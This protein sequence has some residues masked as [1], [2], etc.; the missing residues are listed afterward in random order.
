[1]RSLQSAKSLSGKLWPTGEFS[2]GTVKHRPD[3]RL[4]HRP[5]TVSLPGDRG[6]DAAAWRP[7]SEGGHGPI[8]LSNV[9][10]SQK[11]AS[12]PETYG[13]KGMTGYGKKMVKSLGA[14]IDRD[15]PNHRVTFATVTMPS[16]PQSE[17]RQMAE[18]WPEFV[19]QL[20]MKLQRTLEKKGL[21]KVACSVSEVQPKRLLGRGEGYLHLHL[22]WLNVPGR[23]GN[24]TVDVLDLREWAYKFWRK[25]DVIKDTDHI[26]IDVRAVKGKKANYLAK[27]CSKGGDVVAEFAAD[28]GWAAVPSQWWNMTKVARD[29][30]KSNVHSGQ[31]VG[32]LMASWLNY[33]WDWNDFGLYH[34][35][36]HVEIPIGGVLVTVGWR[37]CLQSDGLAMAIELL[38]N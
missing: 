32:E 21:P 17:R 8:D 34:Y 35:I 6:T 22:L 11:R 16:V 29:W 2:Y 33:A 1:M 20:L 18:L 26:N 23:H 4:D 28:N 7:D 5:V 24:W 30:V 13:R 15:Y 38:D 36:H 10:N 31:A 9:S 25:R 14:L 3:E 19:R 27:Y 37:G 12:R